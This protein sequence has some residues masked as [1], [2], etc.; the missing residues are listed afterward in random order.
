MTAPREEFRSGKFT[1][2][3]FGRLNNVN[4]PFIQYREDDSIETIPAADSHERSPCIEV[5]PSRTKE[6]WKSG[7]ISIEL[8]ISGQA[9][10]D[11]ASACEAMVTVALI[12]EGQ[13]ADD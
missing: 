7:E 10:S 6:P 8:E 11:V 13:E 4:P 1:I 9:A 5:G 3:R 12:F 2:D